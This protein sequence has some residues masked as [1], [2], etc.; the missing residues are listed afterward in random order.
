MLLCG[1]LWHKT[2]KCIDFRFDVGIK[3]VA[4]CHADCD[5][6][7][8]ANDAFIVVLAIQN[9]ELNDLHFDP[10]SFGVYCAGLQYIGLPHKNVRK[11]LRR[12]L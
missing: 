2:E 9:V 7:R 8:K 10:L 4:L 11:V 12:D 3:R 6:T 5:F 1:L